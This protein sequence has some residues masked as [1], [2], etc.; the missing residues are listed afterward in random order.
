M[1]LG[2]PLD[3]DWFDAL[4]DDP[5]EAAALH[6]MHVDRAQFVAKLG[7]RFSGMNGFDGGFEGDN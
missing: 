3:K 4:A 6:A 5:A 2:Q 1:A 7:G